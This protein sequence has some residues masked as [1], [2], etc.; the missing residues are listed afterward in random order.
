MRNALSAIAPQMIENGIFTTE[1][2]GKM[3]SVFFITYAIGQL[4]NGILGDKIKAHNLIGV[5]LV[6]SGISHFLIV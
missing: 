4:F 5:G 1:V 3:S 6:F 2:V